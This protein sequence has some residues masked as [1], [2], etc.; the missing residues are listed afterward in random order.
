M[1]A[2]S[3]I[4]CGNRLAN[5][6]F[7]MS[8]MSARVLF[9]QDWVLCQSLLYLLQLIFNHRFVIEKS[10]TSFSPRETNFVLVEWKTSSSVR[11]SFL[12]ET[13]LPWYRNMSC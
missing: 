4:C 6:F 11:S 10:W 5:P 3:F 13:W 9:Q 2:T 8:S 12:L 1:I 7:S